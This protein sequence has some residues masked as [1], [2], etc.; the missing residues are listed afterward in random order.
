MPVWIIQT[1][2]Y[3]FILLRDNIIS[4]VFSSDIQWESFH[5]HL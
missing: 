2:I 5:T 4:F 3:C 1:G